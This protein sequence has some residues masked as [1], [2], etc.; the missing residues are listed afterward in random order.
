MTCKPVG[1]AVP[2][3]RFAGT[4]YRRLP[5]LGIGYRVYLEEEWRPSVLST[6]ALSQGQ[7]FGFQDPYVWLLT[8]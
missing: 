7:S 5:P 2:I 8:D 1:A 3:K 6:E 4:G